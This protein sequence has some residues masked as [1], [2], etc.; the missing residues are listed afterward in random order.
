MKTKVFAP[1]AA[2]SFESNLQPPTVM[3]SGHRYYASGQLLIGV[4]VLALRAEW[5]AQDTTGMDLNLSPSN[6]SASNRPRPPLGY[7]C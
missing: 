2:I 5:S 1:K 4:K 7:P 3:L 6:S